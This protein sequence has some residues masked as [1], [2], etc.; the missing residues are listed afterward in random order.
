MKSEDAKCIILDIDGVIIY[1]KNALNYL[2]SLILKDYG[3]ELRKEDLTHIYGKPEPEIYQTLL[4]LGYHIPS[5]EDYLKSIEKHRNSVFTYYEL[6][7]LGS[8]L[9]H[10]KENHTL[11]VATNRTRKSAERILNHFRIINLFDFIASASEFSPKPSGEM[12]LA[13]IEKTR[14]KKQNTVFIGDTEIDR[15]AGEEA[16]I[17]TIL[18]SFE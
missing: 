17:K 12:L 16:G 11:C 4:R 6:T 7:P 3:Q 14:S 2:Y 1:S 5:Y 15:Q 10:L 18:V 9:N 8:I 13:C